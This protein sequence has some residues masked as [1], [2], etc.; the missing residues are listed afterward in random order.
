MQDPIANALTV[1]VE[2]YFQSFR[3]LGILS[4]ETWGTFPSRVEYQTYGLLDLLDRSQCHATF[5]LLGLVAEHCKALVVEIARRGHEV[6]T[7][8]YAHEPIYW[9]SRQAFYEDVS[10][11]KAIIEDRCR[12]P[13]Y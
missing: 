9:Q 8:G 2:E 3:P 12:A 6:A 1:D 10:K 4:P 13:F 7:H 5:F 11:A